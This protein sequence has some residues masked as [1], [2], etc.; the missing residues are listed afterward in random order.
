[1][2]EYT[3]AFTDKMEFAR[4]PVPD[5]LNKI[6]KYPKGKPW[7]YTVSVKQ[8]RTFEAVF[9]AAKSVEG[10]MKRRSAEKVEL[11]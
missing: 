3:N 8:E 2:D 5:E 11:G 1:M 9:W 6:D 4:R 10:M 7:E